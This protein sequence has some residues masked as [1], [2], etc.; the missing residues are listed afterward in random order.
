[1][2]RQ[3]VPESAERSDGKTQGPAGPPGG[4]QA[5]AGRLAAGAQPGRLQSPER[6]DGGNWR[7]PQS[8]AFAGMAQA[9]LWL[10][11]TYTKVH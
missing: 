11:P 2:V 9:K 7:S 8:G 3:A 4:A 10:A 1:M 5:D 6:S